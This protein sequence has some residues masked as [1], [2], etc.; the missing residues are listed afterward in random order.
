MDVES[1]IQKYPKLNFLKSPAFLSLAKEDQ[2]FILGCIEDALFWVDLK[3]KPESSNGFKF[4]A[5]AYA[6]QKAHAE[7]DAQS[8][9]GEARERFLR[10]TQDLYTKFNPFGDRQGSEAE[11]V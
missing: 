5:A 6:L 2:D 7:A 9:T 4:L 8:L 1:L 3:E 11:T 10:S